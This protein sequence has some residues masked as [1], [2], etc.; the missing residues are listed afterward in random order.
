[1]KF[2]KIVKSLTTTRVFS[3]NISEARDHLA[4][5]RTF[6]AWL[7]TGFTISAL[8]IV[9]SRVQVL[10]IGTPLSDTL[11]IFSKILS[12]VF[13]V[14]GLLFVFFGA[15]RFV[16]VQNSLSEKVF[17][18]SGLLIFVVC[19]LATLTFIATFIMVLII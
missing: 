13:V 18:S 15:V 1:M 10:S 16:S 14:L 8:G 12:L 17:P 5:E 7:R 19:I 2:D 3:N 11:N 9:L 4:N 6:L